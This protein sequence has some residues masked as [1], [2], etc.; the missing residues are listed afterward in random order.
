MSGTETAHNDPSSPIIKSAS[1]LVSSCYKFVEQVMRSWHHFLTILRFSA[2]LKA[3]IYSRI[4]SFS[5]DMIELA[6]S[7]L[8]TLCD[9][10]TWNRDCIKLSCR[11][12]IIQLN[13]H[14]RY[15]LMI[16]DH[17]AEYSSAGKGHLLIRIKEGIHIFSKEGLP[18]C[19]V[20]SDLDWIG[21]DPIRSN[22]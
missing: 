4:F 17:C 22:M 16:M 3:L 14:D 8:H 15:I 21:F 6:N 13:S 7:L 5:S 10:I 19:S 18:H 20:G 11:F 9:N 2:M 12:N 1:K